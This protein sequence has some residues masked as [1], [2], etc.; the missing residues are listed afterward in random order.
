MSK[1]MKS[2]LQ[3]FLYQNVKD[4]KNKSQFWLAE[5]NVINAKQCNFVLSQCKCVLSVHISVI[6]FVLSHFGRK[7]PSREGSVNTLLKFE[8]NSTLI[9]PVKCPLTKLEES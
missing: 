9:L 3:L 2:M 7:I 5:S 6:T 8:V 1:I 4:M